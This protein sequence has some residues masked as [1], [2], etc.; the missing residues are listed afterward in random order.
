MKLYCGWYIVFGSALRQFVCVT[1]S[2]VVVGV[3]MI[4]VINELGWKVWQFTFRLS[5]A[6]GSGAIP[7]VIVVP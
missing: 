6:L 3:L 7:R 1:A 2:Q 5:V 4:S